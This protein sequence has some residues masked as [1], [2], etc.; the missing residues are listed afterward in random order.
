VLACGTLFLRR[1]E[2]QHSLHPPA[3]GLGTLPQN[4]CPASLCAPRPGVILQRS[5]K[6][7]D[8]I[9]V[10]DRKPK[11]VAEALVYSQPGML[12]TEPLAGTQLVAPARTVHI[13]IKLVIQITLHALLFHPADG[14]ARLAARF[15]KFVRQRVGHRSNIP[16]A[17]E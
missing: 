16:F 9:M 7:V 12:M 5:E 2:S 1:E 11:R 10:E 13:F 8:D 4:G 14:A 15:Q 6:I 3:E 17:K